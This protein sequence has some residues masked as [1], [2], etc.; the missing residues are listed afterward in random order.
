MKVL[1]KQQYV[2]TSVQSIH[3]TSIKLYIVTCKN[4]K[5]KL[6]LIIYVDDE[7]IFSTHQQETKEVVKSKAKYMW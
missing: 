4:N 1:K 7:G 5:K 2:N 3:E 6:Y